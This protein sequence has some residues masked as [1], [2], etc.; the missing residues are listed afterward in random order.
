M[1]QFVTTGCATH[2]HREF[3]IQLAEASPIPDVAR[4][5]IDYFE[6]GVAAGTTFL[7][8]QTVRLGWA[9]LRL[10]ERPDGTL[11]VEERGL[12]PKPTWTE[13]VD[14]ALADAWYQKEVC[15]SL[16]LEGELT[17]PLQDDDVMVADCAFDAEQLLMTRFPAEDLPDGV[18]G[19]SL[20]CAEEHDH[21]ERSFVPL[22]AVAANQPGLVQFLALPHD[23][24]VLIDHVEAADAP[25]GAKRI[26]PVVFRG[27]EELIPR[28]GSYLAALRGE[29]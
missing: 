22:M 23:L 27:E 12:T 6:E 3:T 15:A 28:A 8:R 26:R 4:V 17:F 21:G 9:L 2:G 16:G 29:D 10:C 24:V 7:P 14:R 5:L 19:W 11:G 25:A 13:S 20:C 1:Q 18:S